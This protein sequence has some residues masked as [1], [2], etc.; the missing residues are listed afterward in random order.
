MYL[1]PPLPEARTKI[2]E[3]MFSWQAIVTSQA[4]IQSTRYQVAVFSLICLP[5]FVFLFFPVD[6]CEF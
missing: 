1:P 6:E 4:R 3:L 5:V 2:Y